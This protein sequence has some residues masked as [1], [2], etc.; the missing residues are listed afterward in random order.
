MQSA[1]L[2]LVY[3]QRTSNIKKSEHFVIII[4]V[5]CILRLLADDCLLKLTETSDKVQDFITICLHIRIS[6][7]PVM[8]IRYISLIST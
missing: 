4:L 2:N 5:L 6:N 3:N 1:F 8:S 7:L